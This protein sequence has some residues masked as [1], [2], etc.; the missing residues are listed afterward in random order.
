MAKQ[1]CHSGFGKTLTHCVK[2]FVGD[3]VKNGK[4]ILCFAQNK[5]DDHVVFQPRFGD[6]LQSATFF[7]Q[8]FK[9]IESHWIDRAH[10][11]LSG[12]SAITLKRRIT[13]FLDCIAKS[14]GFNKGSKT[15]L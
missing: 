4:C 9:P 2:L 7:I 5:Q 10:P 11:I 3:P 12:Q 6:K 15:R 8:S 13:H 1:K 14:D